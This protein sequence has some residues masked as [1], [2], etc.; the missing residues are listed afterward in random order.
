M[1]R[2]DSHQH[3]WQLSRGD[4]SWL[5]SELTELYQDFLPSELLPLLEQNQIDKTVL[6]QAADTVAETYFMLALAV[7]HDFIAGVVG[8]IDMESPTAIEQLNNLKQ[9]PYFKGIRPMIQDITDINWMLKPE[10][11]PVFDYLITHELTFD[12]LVKPTHLDALYELLQ[13]YPTLKVVIDHG[14]KPDIATNSTPE[15]FEQLALI[16][17][18]TKAYCKLSG[19]VTEAGS[20]PS[21]TKLKPYVDHL[22]SHFGSERLMWGS[23]WPVINLATDYPSWVKQVE[24]FLQNLPEKEQQRIWADTAQ[25]FYSI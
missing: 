19:L 2:I 12:A 7:K 24:S 18:N 23:D 8:W 13:R 11:A 1:K 25:E 17:K 10:L 15:W 3:F 22:L 16:A 20:D 14:A 6:V 4:Y 9:S 5:S 21:S